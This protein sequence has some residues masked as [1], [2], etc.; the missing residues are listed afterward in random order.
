MAKEV[1]GK[2]WKVSVL[3]EEEKGSMESLEVEGL[4]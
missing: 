3:E 4:G 1:S 2:E